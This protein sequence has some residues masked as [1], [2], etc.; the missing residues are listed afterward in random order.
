VP[1]RKTG[2]VVVRVALDDF[3]VRWPH[4][5]RGKLTVDMRRWQQFLRVKDGV[6]IYDLNAENITRVNFNGPHL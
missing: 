3:D 1:P 6:V 5:H 2:L 4:P